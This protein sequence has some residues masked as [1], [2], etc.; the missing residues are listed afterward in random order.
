MVDNDTPLVNVGRTA[1]HGS[2]AYFS[3]T[4][5][6]LYRCVD[7]AFGIAERTKFYCGKF[8]DL[9]GKQGDPIPKHSKTCKYFGLAKG[10][11]IH[12]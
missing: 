6:S 4:G 5:P 2:Y 3:G 1:K 11:G 7:C 12:D 9:T 10:A 8:Y